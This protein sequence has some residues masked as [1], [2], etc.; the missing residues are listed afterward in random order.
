MLNN[1]FTRKVLQIV[2]K[3]SQGELMTYTQVANQ[4]GSPK[5]YRAVGSIL[6]RNY[7]KREWQ[8]PLNNFEPVPCHRV[9]CNDGRIGGFAKGS[10]EKERILVS[11]GHVVD[12]GKIK[13][14]N[15]VEIKKDLID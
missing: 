11:E 14:P 4:A 6:N 10:K 13:L 9:I 5:A 12:A 7:R 8:L 2:A 3:I 15:L 1:D